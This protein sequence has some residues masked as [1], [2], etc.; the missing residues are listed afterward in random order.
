[1][2][3]PVVTFELGGGGV[4]RSKA[5][6]YCVTRVHRQK[7][8][9][10]NVCTYVIIQGGSN[11]TG[12]SCDFLTHKSSRSYLNHLVSRRVLRRKKFSG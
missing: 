6:I 12:T 2:G 8:L 3:T 10:Q 7:T 9:L 4:G 5:D 1:M 11:M